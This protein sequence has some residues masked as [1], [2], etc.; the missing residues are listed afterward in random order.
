MP[1]EQEL[2]NG[3]GFAAC[4]AF[5]QPEAFQKGTGKADPERA[6]RKVCHPSGQAFQKEGG[7]SRHNERLLHTRKFVVGGGLGLS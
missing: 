7:A 4:Q 3:R 2:H 5:A 1:T 6:E